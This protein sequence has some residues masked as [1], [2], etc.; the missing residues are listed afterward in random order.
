MNQ[1][2]AKASRK[3]LA[4]L[5]LLLLMVLVGVSLNSPAVGANGQSG[6]TLS[7]EKTAFGHLTRTFHWTIDK[8]VSPDT[9]DL[10]EGD[11]GTSQYTVTVTKDSGTEEAFVDGEI[12]VKNGGAVATENLQIVDELYDG[13]PPPKDLIATVNVDLSAHPILDPEERFCYS[14][15]VDIPSSSVH[16]GGEYKDTAHITITNHSGHLGEPFGPSPSATTKLPGTQTSTND[17]INVD[18][19]NGGSW[20][21]ETSGSQTYDKTFTCDADE[22]KHDNT[23]T[24]RET[25]QSD[26]ASVTVNCYPSPGKIVIIKD[27]I[28]DDPQDFHYTTTG[29]LTPSTFDLDDDT[30][31]TLSNTQTYDNVAPGSYS[32]TEV[33]PLPPPWEFN[34]LVCDDPTH[35]TTVSG[36][37]ANIQL[38]ADETVTCTFTN[39]DPSRVYGKIIVKK[40]THPAND[41]TSFTFSLTDGPSSLSQSF[42]LRDGESHDSGYVTPGSGYVAAETV[43]EGWDLTDASCDD[44]SPVSNIDVG[45]GET[46]TCTF[47][48]ESS[49]GEPPP[50]PVGGEIYLPNKLALLSPYLALIGVVGALTTAFAIRRRR[51]T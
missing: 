36:T 12:C 11:S 46:V 37:T 17:V 48:D 44:G 42:S 32:V 39:I 21:F 28:P 18:D 6:T 2:P 26:A 47:T 16:A 25:S 24:I 3:T 31:S 1:F 35:D 29:G 20:T 8:S 40:V 45:A 22:G 38:D 34:S 51:E 41:P 23:A 33:L 15:R 30:D 4:M 27:A 13:L 9:W 49:G 19:T 14:Y 10:F 5:V 50:P 43:P 7:A